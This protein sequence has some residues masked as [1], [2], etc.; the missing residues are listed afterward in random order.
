MRILKNLKL[1]VATLIIPVIVSSPLQTLAAQPPI[2]TGAKISF[3]FDDGYTSALTQAATTLA[4]YGMTGTSYVIT[5]CVGM[6]TAPNA[7]RADTAKTYMTWSQIQSLQNTYGWEIGSHTVDHQCLASN[8][9]VDPDDCQANTLTIAQVDAEL[10]NSKAALAANG[11]NATTIAT[12]YGDYNQSVLAEI[13]K[14]YAAHRGFADTGFNAAPYN[15]YIIRDQIGTGGVGVAKMEKYVDQA[16]ANHQWLVFSFHDILAKKASKNANDYEY[17]TA[18]L[19]TI[20]AYVKSKSVPVVNVRDGLIKGDNLL[21]DSTFDNGISNGWTTD[22]PSNFVADAGNHGSYPSPSKSVA[23]SAAGSNAHLFS[24][25]VAV[26]SSN[27]YILKSFVNLSSI[28]SGSVGYY[29]DEYDSNGN[30]ISGQYKLN[31]S[32]AW[33]QTAGFEYKPTSAGVASA[34]LQVILP[35]NSS[36]HGYLDNFEWIN[37][38]PGVVVPPPNL[39]ANGA[40]DD[41]IADG[42]TTDGSA[43]IVAD[44]TNHG[45]P[46][47][48]VNSVKMTAVAGTTHLFSPKASVTNSKTYNLS[49]YVNIN[50]LTTGEVGFYIDEYDSAG[51]WISGHYVTGARSVGATTVSFQYVPTSANVASASLQIILVGN[52]GIVAYVDNVLWTQN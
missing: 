38:N 31:V 11:V 42:W 10:A 43:N 3:T 27:A 25:S 26:N 8:A 4:K 46:A 49:T 51:N 33:T 23:F 36:A 50:Q 29:I 13:S 44:A 15:Q 32:F 6:T 39:V 40:F 2:N 30:W 34:R 52:S 35:A 45:S 47:N 7:C 5:N 22:S 20:A 19:D 14:Y 18:N 9:S 16:I 41:G 1:L 48:P 17:S 24:P 21:A 12:P 28:A 37:E